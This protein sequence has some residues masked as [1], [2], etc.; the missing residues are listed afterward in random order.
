MYIDLYFGTSPMHHHCLLCYIK[1][2]WVREPYS[3]GS[4]K[5]EGSIFISRA[6]YM[7]LSGTAGL[8]QQVH[9]Q[10]QMVMTLTENSGQPTSS[11]IQ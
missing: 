9:F 4:V 7:L 6:I 1:E 3:E 5:S 2:I 10:A 8:G 11:Y